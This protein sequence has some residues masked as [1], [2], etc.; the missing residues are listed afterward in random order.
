MKRVLTILAIL[1]LPLSV[2][3]MTPVTD[4]DLSNVT[5]Q[6]GVSI[7]QD[8]MMNIHMDVMAWGD[9][10][11]LGNRG[12]GTLT[13]NA[14]T[15]LNPWTTVSTGG[16]IGINNFD[17]TVQVKARDTDT[18]GAATGANPNATYGVYSPTSYPGLRPLTIDVATTLL[19]LLRIPIFM[20]TA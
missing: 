13:T 3:A 20:A 2:W 6:A 10:D 5:G 11:G 9:V 14:S 7:N 16:Y 12:I 8:V 15:G 4:S 18:F 1:L 19:L 17:M